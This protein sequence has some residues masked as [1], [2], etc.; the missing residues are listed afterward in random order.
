MFL[1]FV[2]L[3]QISGGIV[4]F[5]DVYLSLCKRRNKKPS[6]VA[7]ELGINKSNVS[8]WKNNGYTPRGEALQKIA[9]YFD[10]ATDYLLTGEET[11]KAPAPEGGRAVSDDDIK[12]ALFG[13]DGE[14]TDAMYDEVKRF[15][16]M[17]KLREEAEK[18]KK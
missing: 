9:D 15:A 3:V 12:F 11:E 2:R 16:Q 5:Y 17:V 7:A 4:V 1:N 8:N 18:Q 14:I 10:V 13:G 6:V